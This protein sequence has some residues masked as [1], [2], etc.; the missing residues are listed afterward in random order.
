MPLQ[1][2]SRPDYRSATSLAEEVLRNAILNGELLP[3][4]DLREVQIAERLG[5]SRTPV[6]EALLRLGAAGLV[7][8]THNRGARVRV[9]DPKGLIDIYELR[10]ELES[11]TAEKAARIIDAV[12]LKELDASSDRFEALCNLEDSRAL[13]RENFTFHDIVHRASGNER[14]PGLIRGLIEIPALFQTYAYYDHDRRMLSAT[15]HRAITEAL[16]EGDSKRAG[17]LMREHILGAKAMALEAQEKAIALE[18]Q[19]NSSPQES[20]TA[21]SA[22]ST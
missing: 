14:A 5:L 19:E 22:G 18:A 20:Q 15:H 7:E 10:A 8:M 11:Y 12:S 16:R 1:D 21:S 3:G 2:L 13:V 6:R 4:E 17:E 9:T